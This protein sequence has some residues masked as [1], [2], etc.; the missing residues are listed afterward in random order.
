MKKLYFLLFIVFSLQA[1][2]QVIEFPDQNLK[3]K[4]LSAN[5]MNGVAAAPLAGYVALDTNNDGEIEISETEGITYL[6]LANCGI[7]DI[8]G[9]TSFAS[10][11]ALYLHDNP[12]QAIDL[13][14]FNTLT[15]LGI[16]G[17]S[18]PTVDLSPVPQLLALHCLYTQISSL[19][20]SVV[21]NLL[22]L[23]CNNSMLTSLD[24]S[25]NAS[26]MELYCNY[27]QL[28]T[29]DLS[30]NL[31]LKYFECNH[32]QLVSI[33]FDGLHQYIEIAATHNLLTTFDLSNAYSP[34]AMVINVENNPLVSIYSKNGGH[35]FINFSDG[36]I[37][38]YICADEV[39]IGLILDTLNPSISTNCNVNSY[40]SFT[41]G[42]DFYTIS[43]TNTMD[44]NNNGCDASDT[45]LPQLKFNITDGYETGSIIANQS[46][47]YSIPVLAGTHTITPVIENPSYFTITPSDV[48]IS[49]PAETSP[50][51]QNFCITPNGIHQDID[52][53]I[54]PVNPAVPGFDAHY[55]IIYRNLGNVSVVLGSISLDYNDDVL[56]LTAA[57]PYSEVLPVGSLYWSFQ[58]LKPFETRIIDLTFNLNTPTETPALNGDDVLTFQA[59][60]N[61]G[62]GFDENTA[63][64]VMNLQQ[65]VVNSFDPNDKTCLEGTAISPD[66][67]G[68]YVH[69]MIRFENTG[70]FAAQNIVVKD[71]IDTT[72]FD[73]SSL[74]ALNGSHPYVIRITGNKVEF[75]FEGINLPFD[76][77]NNDGYVVFKIKTLPT[78]A[79]GDS[80]SNTASIYFDFNHP[81]VTEPA[82]TTFVE[83]GTKDF[84]FNNYFTIYPNPTSGVLNITSKQNIAMQS[85]SIYNVLGQIVVSVPNTKGVNS[86]DVSSLSTGNYFIKVVSDKGIS[87]TKFVKQ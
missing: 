30:H 42:G 17:Y 37:L 58:N 54:V 41:P 24:V 56:D 22:V 29:L 23:Q 57:S 78:L 52:V 4:L 66:M 63:D 21:P 48:S 27:N 26:L 62:A 75:I 72:K 35:E 38:E 2:S 36:P 83:L 8:T 77:A 40:C 80:F 5:A 14:G 74:I 18:Y 47:A 46:G 31:L 50:L 53:N 44:S 10:L 16:N 12:L 6:Y 79:L 59:S 84:E 49:F 32:N 51:D 39:E 15:S 81:I 9:L 71:I 69:Y 20:L 68:Q 67:I 33:G 82:V 19:D 45:V 87:N 43:G 64:N 70:T 76:D 55:K 11:E 28:T 86:V 60:S 73:V 1:A 61:I 65:T 25:S 85:I 13:T 34:F 3:N 7:T